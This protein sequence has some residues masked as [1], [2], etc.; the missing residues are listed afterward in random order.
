M[1]GHSSYSWANWVLWEN[2]ALEDSLIGLIGVFIGWLLGLGSSVYFQ[3]RSIKRQRH[4]T[5]KERVYSPLYDEI[6][7]SLDRLKEGQSA[8]MSQWIRITTQDHLGYLIEPPE[9]YDKL[10]NFYTET[11]RNLSSAIELCRTTFVEAVK[12]DL[13]SRLTP[14][15]TNTTTGQATL[16]AIGDVATGV[17]AN[18][19]RGYV[20]PGDIHTFSLRLE[21][22]KPYVKGLTGTF[23]E[24]FDM[25]KKKVENDDT[26]ISYRRIHEQAVSEATELREMLGNNLRDSAPKTSASTS[27]QPTVPPN[28]PPQENIQMRSA[29]RRALV[30]LGITAVIASIFAAM[31]GTIWVQKA[32]ETSFFFNVPPVGSPIPHATYFPFYI[33]EYWII[34]WVAYAG[35]EFVYFSVDWFPTTWRMT[36]HKIATTLIGFYVVYISAFVPLIY[37]DVVYVTDP[38]WQ[39]VIFAWI[40]VFIGILEMDFV[41]W[42]WGSNRGIISRLIRRYRTWRRRD[43]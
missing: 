21:S 39:S 30:V 24:Y 7:E 14:V 20:F 17:G 42:A 37:L 43:L 25:W 33:L 36:G 12:Y 23:P 8:T 40:I 2:L 26:L 35:F 16:Q 22:L 3:E 10:R 15:D 41:L 34:F 6:E 29:E 9:L 31:L 4:E 1:D 11:D 5:T 19:V 18:L 27:S 28:P 13:M 32:N 38:Y